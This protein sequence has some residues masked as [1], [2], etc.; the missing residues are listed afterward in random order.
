[1]NAALR[2]KGALNERTLTGLIRLVLYWRALNQHLKTLP[3]P[4]GTAA[5]AAATMEAVIWPPCGGLRWAGC[6]GAEAAAR[7]MDGAAA[8]CSYMMEGDSQ[9]R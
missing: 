4:L 3:W 2:S 5:V 1:M 7:M 8:S 6:D 9:S